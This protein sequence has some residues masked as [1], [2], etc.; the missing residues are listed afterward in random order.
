[1]DNMLSHGVRHA[2]RYNMRRCNI[3]RCRVRHVFSPATVE[4]FSFRDLPP[5][6]AVRCIVVRPSGQP[7]SLAAWLA[8]P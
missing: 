7:S 6:G 8:T 5:L 2:A 1:M 3:Q 4:R